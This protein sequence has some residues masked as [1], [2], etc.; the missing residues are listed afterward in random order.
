MSLKRNIIANYASQIYVT[1]IGIV[2]VPLYIKYMGAEAYGL[3]GFFAMLQA[4]FNLLDMGLSS[5]MSRESA[6]FNG[7]AINTLEYRQLARALE[8]LFAV[9][10][11][12]GGALL[13]VLAEPI[14][15]RWLNVKTLTIHETTVS[16]QL[17]AVIVA[18]RWLSGFY[19]GVITGAERLVFLSGLNSSVATVRFALVL[20]ILMFIDS[21][22]RVFFSFQLLVAFGELIALGWSA[23]SMLPSVPQGK[24]IAWKW[25]PIKPVLRFAL[26][27]AFTTSVWVL[28]TQTDKLILSKI[29][30]LEDYGYFAVAVVLAS[31]IMTLSGPI[32]AALLPRMARLQAEGRHDDLID[33]YRKSTRM[34]STVVV[35][36]ALV[37]SVFAPQVLWA[38]T[39][40]ET[41]VH[42]A[43]KVLTLYA[44]GYGFLAVG[45]FPYYL[46]YAKGDLKLHLIGNVLFVILLIPSVIF[47]TYRY[48]MTGAG[49]AWLLA[50]VIYFSA[51]TAVVHRHVEPGLHLRWLFLDIARPLTPVVCVAA[52]IAYL[53]SWNENRIF[54]AIQLVIVTSI[55]L[56][57][58]FIACKNILIKAE[59]QNDKCK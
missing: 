11:L 25:A 48:G 22:P 2:M 19:R 26:S 1:A 28:V 6:R 9:I 5:T 44:L 43:S 8:G 31:G 29:L 32:N 40:N 59:P 35:P 20:P 55:F 18:L 7:G 27:I 58:A 54:M 17:M 34:V 23:Y 57:A 56:F 21:T 36:I 50:N 47:S 42:Q 30:S 14:A 33:V 51:W 53:M 3:V 52:V 46:Q 41:L 12:M 15:T 24:R 10:A 45:A 49:W 37:L 13:F 4:W 38:W 39:G 16:M